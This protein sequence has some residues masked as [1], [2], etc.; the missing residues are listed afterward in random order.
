[1]KEGKGNRS[2]LRGWVQLC[3]GALLIWAFVFVLAPAATGI[4]WV[5]TVIRNVRESGID[6]T[7]LYYTEIEEFSD[8]ERFMQDSNRYN[9][10]LN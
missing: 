7:A 3:I 10:A 5:E 4:P 9:P 1:M 2:R 6:A 8:A